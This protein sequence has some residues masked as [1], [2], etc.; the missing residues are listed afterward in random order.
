MTILTTERLRLEPLQDAHLNAL[1]QI[2]RD[3]EV[4]RYITGRAQTLEETQAMID[5]VKARWEQ[6]GYS[7]WGFIERDGGELIGAG[8]VQH[9]GRDPTRELETGWRLRRDKWG[10]GYAI[11]AARSMAGFAFDELQA[12]LLCAVCIPENTK[13][14]GVMTRLGMRYRG[15]ETW[16]D[17]QMAAY[18]VTK[19][20]WGVK[21]K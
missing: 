11:E 5:T 9:L 15:L 19:A 13:S 2:N 12:D 18:E 14:S 10:M 4:M 6:Y 20:E 17:M 21:W 3:A 8:C 7:W 16:Y 1:F